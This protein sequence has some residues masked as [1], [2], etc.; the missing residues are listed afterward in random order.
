MDA[1]VSNMLKKAGAFFAMG[2]TCAAVVIILFGFLL[3][4]I[5]G[6]HGRGAITTAKEFL[7]FGLAVCISKMAT[8][9]KNRLD[10]FPK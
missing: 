2:T 9:A 8:L 7:Y 5:T 3:D 1:R 10:F 4:G 6:G